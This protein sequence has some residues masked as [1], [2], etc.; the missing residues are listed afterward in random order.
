MAIQRVNSLKYFSQQELAAVVAIRCGWVR[1]FWA[2][3]GGFRNW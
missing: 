3:L 1:A 2:D